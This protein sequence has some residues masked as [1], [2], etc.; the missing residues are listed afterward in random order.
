M[1]RIITV[2][3][4]LFFS[5]SVSGEEI[6]FEIID[7]DGES[8]VGQ[9]A[10]LDADSIQINSDSDSLTFSPR[11]IEIV[12]NLMSNP[13]L[14]QKTNDNQLN[15]LNLPQNLRQKIQRTMVIKGQVMGINEFGVIVPITNTPRKTGRLPSS[16]LQKLRG[17]EKEN[18]NGVKDN[19]KTPL[20]PNSV[21]VIDLLDGSRLVA[22]SF[23]L[24]EQKAV[25]KLLDHN[26]AEQTKK[27]EKNKNEKEISETINKNSV[28][29]ITIPIEQI[30]SVRFAVKN[31]AEI[32]EPSAQWIKYTKELGTT[33]D[34]L[35]ISKDD[36]FDI[37]NGIVSEITR[38]SV[39]FTIDNEKLPIKRNKIFGMILHSP[40]RDAIKQKTVYN[41]QITLWTGAQLMLDSFALKKI[42]VENQDDVN[43]RND[44]ADNKT[45]DKNN[46]K[47]ELDETIKNDVKWSEDKIL[48]KSLAGFSGETLLSE[49]DN[50]IFSRGNSLYLSD[51]TPIIRERLFP[52]EWSV[53]GVSKPDNSSPLVK[54]KLFQAGKFGINKDDG[55][56]IDPSLVSITPSVTLNAKRAIN[57]PIPAIEGVVLGG[58]SYRRG[59]TLTPK[60]KLE[61]LIN[62]N[63]KVY[64]AIRGF[65]GI[66]DR[67]K[68]NGRAKLSIEVDG[69]SIC[70]M[71]ISG[72]DMVKLLRFDLPDTHKKIT[73]TVDFAENATESIPVSIG[74]LKL[75]K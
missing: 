74:D 23:V 70:E 73:I 44:K 35:V 33:G 48:W 25:C 46:D 49:I 75:I 3:F 71:E 62:D 7:V 58:V 66:D 6:P 9:I 55:G 21:I 41:G 26:Y 39:I 63:E 32:A 16:L 27:D 52:F 13:F 53:S 42:S 20:F 15:N 8:H 56:K 64:S 19:P 40:N 1:K 67:L 28:T 51:L 30:Y 29:E 45:D 2:F 12:Q 50:I 37:Y 54:L 22:T 38:E 14:Q 61:Y 4:L 24:K 11:R 34:R 10:K 72:V 47:S 59:L 68:P 60:T 65:V 69:K 57:Q 5:V 18:K 31:F 17:E 36:T 43:N